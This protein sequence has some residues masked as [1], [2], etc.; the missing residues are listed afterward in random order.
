MPIYSSTTTNI[1][2]TIPRFNFIW[3]DTF[4]NSSTRIKIVNETFA[5]A[6][7]VYTDK[8]KVSK[9]G[10]QKTVLMAVGTT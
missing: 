6:A 3:K 5:E 8:S 9:L 7:G 10:L 4:G 1:N 2:R